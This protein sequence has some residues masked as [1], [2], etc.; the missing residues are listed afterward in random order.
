MININIEKVGLDSSLL[1]T[2][3]LQTSVEFRLFRTS[4]TCSQTAWR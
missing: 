4:I 2:S 1:D 3:I